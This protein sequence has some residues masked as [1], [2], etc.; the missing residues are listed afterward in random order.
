MLRISSSVQV[1]AH[2]EEA[3]KLPYLLSAFADGHDLVQHATPE[4]PGPMHEACT[5]PDAA[6]PMHAPY[7]FI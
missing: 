7:Q 1:W 3:A 5:A 6:V 4:D 2:P